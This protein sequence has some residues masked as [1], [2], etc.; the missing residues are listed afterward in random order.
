MMMMGIGLFLLVP[1]RLGAFDRWCHASIFPLFLD[2]GLGS[3]FKI[4]IGII[5]LVPTTCQK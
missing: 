4:V 3:V 1:F 2:S 5:P